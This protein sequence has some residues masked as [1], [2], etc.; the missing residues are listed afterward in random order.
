MQLVTADA[1]C[2]DETTAGRAVPVVSD[3]LDRRGPLFLPPALTSLVFTLPRALCC[4]SDYSTFEFSAFPA[5]L[6]SSAMGSVRAPV[7]HSPAG[8]FLD[9]LRQIFLGITSAWG[10]VS[11]WQ[12]GRV[13]N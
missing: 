11:V 10:L 2:S 6:L 8:G 1:D 12:R 3:L 5:A 13:G 9:K 7:S 4:T